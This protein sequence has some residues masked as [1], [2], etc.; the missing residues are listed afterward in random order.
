MSASPP[1]YMDPMAPLAPTIEPT[2]APQQPTVGGN[3]AAPSATVEAI[4]KIHR[5]ALETSHKEIER[6]TQQKN[7]FQSKA[8]ALE[9]QI[10]ELQAQVS[11]YKTSVEATTTKKDDATAFLDALRQLHTAINAAHA[12]AAA[13]VE[14][15]SVSS[16]ESINLETAAKLLAT[17]TA[18][19]SASK[20]TVAA[21]AAAPLTY[22]PPLQVVTAILAAPSGKAPVQASNTRWPYASVVVSANF[23]KAVIVEPAAVEVATTVPAV[24]IVPSKAKKLGW[25]LKKWGFSVIDAAEA[26][27]VELATEPNGGPQHGGILYHVVMGITEDAQL[28]AADGSQRKEEAAFASMIL[29]IEAHYQQV[30]YHSSVHAA[31]VVQSFY[32]LIG[33][34]Q[35]LPPVMTRV[36]FMAALIAAAGHDV[37]HPGKNNGYVANLHDPCSL[38]CGFKSVLETHHIATIFTLLQHQG[39]DFTLDWKKE[40]VEIFRSIVVDAVLGTD[41]AFHKD[42]IVELH[43]RIGKVLNGQLSKGFEFVA[44]ATITDAQAAIHRKVAVKELLHVAD[45]GALGKPLEVAHPWGV[46]VT[47]EFFEQGRCE[48]AL[49]LPISPLCDETKSPFAESQVG[50]LDF[51]ILPFYGAIVKIF[52]Y[53]KLGALTTNALANRAVYVAQCANGGASMAPA[54]MLDVTPLHARAAQPAPVAPKTFV[55]P[56]YASNSV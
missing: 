40:D 31:D 32:S 37:G 11:Q 48:A 8:V 2:T 3:A 53:D 38:R 21:P 30:P 15:P 55:Q 16:T 33:M 19:V 44:T 52:G 22:I 50:F 14:L 51:V 34:V 47:Q 42:Q 54:P 36:E 43:D 56:V 25:D 45:I 23:D 29:T 39:C 13:K 7:E 10:V 17:L 35:L 41:M 46:R 1:R 12:P 20:P 27:K 18:T 24:T 5:E 28:F 4:N 26:L 49:G 6:L 9:L